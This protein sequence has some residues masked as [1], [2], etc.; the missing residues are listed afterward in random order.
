[1]AVQGPDFVAEADAVALLREATATKCEPEHEIY[2]QGIVD[3]YSRIMRD[4]GL[5]V[6]VFE[7]VAG[8][9]S[10]VGRVRGSGGGRSILFNGHLNSPSSP[11]EDWQTDPYELTRVDGKLYGMGVA[12]LKA[13]VVGML[14]AARAVRESATRGDV[15]IGLGA[16]SELG[17]L[18][19]TK[20]IVERGY[21]AD[22]AIVGEPTN[23]DIINCQ[24]GAV[25]F[26][27][28]VR[29][30]SGLTG[31][32]GVN[33]VHK[34]IRVAQAYVD[35]N[36]D[37]ATRTNPIV[38]AA[39]LSVN[40]I[41]GGHRIS[42]VPDRCMLT[43]DRRLI[44]GE[45]PG[46]AVAEIEGIAEELRA[47]DPEL[48][49]TLELRLTLPPLCDQAV[50]SLAVRAVTDAVLRVRGRAPVIKGI[51]G[52]TELVHLR[53]AGIDGVV[54]GPGSANVI[55]APNEYVTVEELMHTIR[56][57]TAVALQVTR[58]VKE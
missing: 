50:D 49:L 21:R 16:A 27:V 4:F 35:F 10:V 55:H 6:D 56:V 30:R 45:A 40:I 38:G 48:D 32:G 23:M 24:R 14:F 12:D 34:A 33:A 20:A 1:M 42:T 57:Y 11:L 39:G 53:E 36:E 51:R 54:C 28:H 22:V 52:F 46:E 15:I 47:E 18:I 43:L 19:G 3:L 2:E 37:L 44:P 8:R 58:M 29:G 17:G 41:Q 26:N 7:K 25:W 13:A 31:Y 9:P 5:E